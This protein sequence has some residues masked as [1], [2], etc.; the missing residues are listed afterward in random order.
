M[1]WGNLGFW[2]DGSL[3]SFNGVIF[4]CCHYMCCISMWVFWDVECRL[5]GL[6]MWDACLSSVSISVAF[7]LIWDSKMLILTPLNFEISGFWEFVDSGIRFFE[8][9]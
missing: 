2:C 7:F 1:V 5:L 3:I 8:D 4:E 9:F 6:H